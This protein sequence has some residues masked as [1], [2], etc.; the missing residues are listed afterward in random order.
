MIPRLKLWWRLVG[1]RQKGE[2]YRVLG[3]E[4]GCF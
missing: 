4:R 3:I 2:A 1:L